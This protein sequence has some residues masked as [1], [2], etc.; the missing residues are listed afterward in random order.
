MKGTSCLAMPGTYCMYP[1]ACSRR[2]NLMLN[3]CP[4]GARGLVS[5]TAASDLP[6]LPICRKSATA[7]GSFIRV[8][9]TRPKEQTCLWFAYAIHFASGGHNHECNRS[10]SKKRIVA[11]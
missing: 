1:V 6:V 8:L 7:T 2:V 3:S 11:E 10:S 9:H 5:Q 4:A